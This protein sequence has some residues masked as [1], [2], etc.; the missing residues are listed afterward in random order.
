ML[1]DG[2]TVD[3]TC[4]GLNLQMRGGDE[5]GL[6]YEITS[7]RDGAVGLGASLYEIGGDGEHW[8]AAHNLDLVEVHAGR[9]PVSRPFVIPADV[10]PARYELV[11][12]VWPGG[13]VGKEGADT[14][15][16]EVCGVVTIVD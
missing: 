1:R 8:D 3:L 7:S 12:E 11:G 2:V 4:D 13:E 10:P 9:E 14:L 5:I 6:V 15:D 16:D